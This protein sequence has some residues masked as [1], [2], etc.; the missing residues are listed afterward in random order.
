[1]QSSPS[2][3]QHTPSGGQR[4]PSRSAQQTSSSARPQPESS[5]C[6]APLSSATYWSPEPS[7]TVEQGSTS[8]PWK[9]STTSKCPMTNFSQPSLSQESPTV[10][11]SRSGRSASLSPSGP[12]AT[13]ASSSSTSTSPTS[14]CHTMPS[15]GTQRWPSSWP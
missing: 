5:R 12:A 4:A 3:K 11:Q 9:H 6:F 13:T 2:S 15:S 14:A 10:P 1:M 7:S 8:C